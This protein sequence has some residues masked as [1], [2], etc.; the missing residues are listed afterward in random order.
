MQIYEITQ[1]KQVNE[2]LGALSAVA[3]G[4]AKAGA[5]QFVQSQT[6]QS[7]TPDKVSGGPN[8]RMGAYKANAAAVGPLAK[9]LQLA[10]AKNIQE[11]L[12]RTKDTAGN[13][14]T[15]LAAVSPGSIAT[16]EPQLSTMVNNAIS[17]RGGASNYKDLVNNSGDDP[18]AKQAAKEVVAAIDKGIAAIMAATM[19]PGN[20]SRQ[21]ATA[22]AE[23]ARDGIAPAQQI[24]TF[25]SGNKSGSGKATSTGKINIV[26]TRPGVWEINGEPLQ[27]AL[28][29]PV[30]AQAWNN[31]QATKP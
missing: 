22:W 3:G 31:L 27:T 13:P 4:I 14:A 19:K 11:F 26:Q 20:N 30:Y 7:M 24:I 17:P 25:D 12:S 1:R 21:L 9:Q 6:G 28:K 18:V 23:L 29:N 8:A 2:I 10:W 5:N 15:N 16:L